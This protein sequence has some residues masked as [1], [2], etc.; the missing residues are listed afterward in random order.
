M[1]IIT[2]RKG[3]ASTW[4]VDYSGVRVFELIPEP[5]EFLAGADVSDILKCGLIP[6]F[7]R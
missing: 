2:N 3:E 1:L 4:V 6:T 7:D 5:A